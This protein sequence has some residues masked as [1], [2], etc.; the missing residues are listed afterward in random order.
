M[1]LAMLHLAGVGAQPEERKSPAELLQRDLPVAVGIERVEEAA[2]VAVP[3]AQRRREL[4]DDVRRVPLP[5]SLAAQQPARVVAQQAEHI[6]AA[7]RR[8]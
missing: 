2:R 5:P 3:R 1:R 7:A 6:A 4:R 8:A